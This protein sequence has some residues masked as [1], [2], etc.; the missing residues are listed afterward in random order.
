MLAQTE[1]FEPTTFGF[2]DQRSTKL[3]YVCILWWRGRIPLSVFSHP[4]GLIGTPCSRGVGGD[5]WDRTK[6]HR[7]KVCCPSVRLYPCNAWIYRHARLIDSACHLMRLLYHMWE[8]V[9]IYSVVA[10]SSTATS[11]NASISPLPPRALYAL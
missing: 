8:E 3:N 6:M 11:N 2:G 9:L 4:N 5:T 10:L 7:V 1:G